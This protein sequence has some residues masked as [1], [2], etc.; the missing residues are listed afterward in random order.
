MAEYIHELQSP[1]AEALPT[2]ISVI[3]VESPLNK[4]FIEQV[5]RDYSISQAYGEW[6]NAVHAQVTGYFSHFTNTNARADKSTIALE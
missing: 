4:S 5:K 1:H 6:L 3:D 2:A